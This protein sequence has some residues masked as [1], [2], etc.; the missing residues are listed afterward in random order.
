[1]RVHYPGDKLHT[2]AAATVLVRVVGRKER[3]VVDDGA[4][5]RRLVRHVVVPALEHNARDVV[6]RRELE[7]GSLVPTRPL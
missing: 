5:Q 2:Q 6:H 1:M 7:L 3:D 4:A